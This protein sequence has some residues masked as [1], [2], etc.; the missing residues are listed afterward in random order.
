MLHADRINK[1]ARFTRIGRNV[2]SLI[3][4]GAFDDPW[5]RGEWVD[6]V[7]SN[8]IEGKSV[9]LVGRPR[10]G[11][12]HISLAIGKS[13]KWNR[14]PG[15][16]QVID[17]P[18]VQ[19]GLH[20]A[21]FRVQYTQSPDWLEGCFYVGDL[22]NK[23]AH[24][25]K[26]TRKPIVLLF[27]S[28]ETA[29]GQWRGSQEKADLVDLLVNV[30]DHPLL[31][32]VV[33]ATPEGW[34]GLA[35]RHAD[36]ASRFVVIRPSEPGEEETCLIATRSMAR[37]GLCRDDGGDAIDEALQLAQP[38]VASETRLGATMRI[39]RAAASSDDDLIG[40]DEVR[41]ACAGV[42][43]KGR[44]WVGSDRVPRVGATVERLE[45]GVRG[46]HDACQI[47]A[48]DQVAK[49]HGLT[50]LDRPLSYVFFGPPGNG[51][52]SSALL[53]Q[54]VL[55]GAGSTPVRIDCTEFSTPFDVKN[56]TAVIT[57]GLVG[58]PAAVVILDEV[59]LLH[60]FGRD[61]LY[62]MLEGRITTA[63]GLVVSTANA[64]VVMTTNEGDEA[65][66]RAGARP[67]GAADAPVSAGRACRELLGA[68]ISSRVTRFV[69]FPPL[70]AVHG[71]AIVRVELGRFAQR[72]GVAGRG[73]RIFA[74]D[75]LVTALAEVGMNSSNG[76]RGIQKTIDAAVAK[77]LATLFGE[78]S[79]RNSRL[80][81]EA[82]MDGDVL[83][84]VRITIE[85][86]H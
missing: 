82:I 28:I 75:Q 22:E 32:L 27:P 7:A 58:R 39:L 19:P 34:A 14:V 51:K 72:P 73:L 16:Q 5:V 26:K 35:E 33:T 44:E 74:T 31:R 17:L 25:R 10:T 4:E 71:E 3:A 29:Y 1:A 81:L 37:R 18:H 69:A 68:A 11:R 63:D 38:H 65:W 9:A 2:E 36:F 67:G 21:A 13:L 15:S 57:T 6:L 76:A 24:A 80:E 55:G 47:L 86:I 64:T 42:L 48:E 84:G 41:S 23:I 60:S 40:I 78:R 54:E 12:T 30:V 8:V 56:L 52:T 70:T 43:G 50:A 66:L 46:Q 53:L 83:E 45:A 77:P 49:A 85:A 61:L 79:V 62:Q 20:P 59:N